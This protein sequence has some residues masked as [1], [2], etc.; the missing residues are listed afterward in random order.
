MKHFMNLFK[1]FVGA[2]ILL[3]TMLGCII[4]V[5]EFMLNIP[6]D[7]NPYKELLIMLYLFFMM[8]VTL[9]LW[10]INVNQD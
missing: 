10:M 1:A 6:I 5:F 8:I 2:F 4:L 3:T 7:N 9:I